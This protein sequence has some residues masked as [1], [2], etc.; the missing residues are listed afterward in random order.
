[1]FY[2]EVQ[3]TVCKLFFHVLAIFWRVWKQLDHP[4]FMIPSDGH[5][6]E[7]P[8]Q[9]FFFSFFVSSSGKK[10]KKTKQWTTQLIYL[11]PVVFHTA[12]PFPW[13]GEC[14]E[15]CLMDAVSPSPLRLLL[16]LTS[17]S[18]LSLCSMFSFCPDS[19]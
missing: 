3:R 6:R 16:S 17:P 12:T 11:R 19:T 7:V 9:C 2:I 18:C 14:W 15:T 5:H 8:H 13:N 1:M 4:G 10:N